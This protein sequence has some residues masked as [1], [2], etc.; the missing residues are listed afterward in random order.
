MNVQVRLVLAPEDPAAKFGR[1]LLAIL[2]A[3]RTQ[4]EKE[5]ITTEITVALDHRSG[6]DVGRMA[7]VLR[8]L[9]PLDTYPELQT[10]TV[11]CTVRQRELMEDTTFQL[12]GVHWER[13]KS[14]PVYLK[15][16]CP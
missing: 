4:K 12:P 3:A 13:V 10:I 6:I 2:E 11:R 5:N 9:Y 8:T 15:D 16:E 14:P 7:G 1:Q